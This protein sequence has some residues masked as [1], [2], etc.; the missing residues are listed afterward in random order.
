MSA[1]PVQPS[2]AATLACEEISFRA[3]LASLPKLARANLIVLAVVAV[4]LTALLSPYWRESADLTHGFLMPV[5]FLFLLLESRKKNERSLP[6][7]MRT[8]MVF[9]LLGFLGIVGLCATGLFAA[10]L[11]WTH[12]LVAFTATLSL[13]LFLTGGLVA[14]STTTT[15]LFPFNWTSLSAIGLWLFCAPIPPGSYTRLTLGLQLA[16]TE[17][18]LSTLHLLGIAANRH[19]NIIDLATTSVGVE[20]ACTGI[21]SLIACVFTGW[22]FSATLVQR[23]WSRALLLLIAAPLAIVMNFLRSLTLTLLANSGI[24]ISGTWHDLTGFAVLGATAA[25]LFWLAWQLEHSGSASAPGS[26]FTASNRTTATRGPLYLQRPLALMLVLAAG[27]AIFFALNTRSAVHETASVPDLAKLLP[28]HADGWRVETATNL[29]QFSRTLQTDHLAQRT[30]LRNV[31]DHIEQITLYVAY[32]KAGQ[33]PV[34]LVASHTPDACWPGSG[35][36]PAPV[37]A[38]R[39]VLQVQQRQLPSAESRKF[40]NNDYPQYVWFWHVYDG[41]PIT[42]RDPYSP[43]ALLKLALRYGFT[44][45]GDQMFVR[46]SSNRPWNALATEPLLAEFFRNLGPLGL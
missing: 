17:S 25:L 42:Y 29:Y 30:Y 35:W 11:A 19:G 7:D 18:V 45:D 12:S 32:W 27:L 16:V 44:H 26:D 10:A 5:I 2:S 9:L 33:A 40:T 39:E 34:S 31:D 3:R 4:A 15:R 22:L 23:P 36:I 21:R 46:I 37:P 6:T 8:W 20:E 1:A 41:H 13:V 14:F 43:S 24:D 28:E 38:P